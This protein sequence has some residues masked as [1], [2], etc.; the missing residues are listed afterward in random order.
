MLVNII[1]TFTHQH[2]H[3]HS[4]YGWHQ[5]AHGADDLLQKTFDVGAQ[6]YQWVSEY[7]T[8][9]ATEVNAL[10]INIGTCSVS[11]ST[12]RDIGML[13][14]GRWVCLTDA[15]RY[16]FDVMFIYIYIVVH[17]SGDN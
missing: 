7:E 2:L 1:S 14:L 5:T 17:K 8:A 10:I 13:R 6:Y 3:L 15:W 4:R 12:Y 9:S 11:M 16:W